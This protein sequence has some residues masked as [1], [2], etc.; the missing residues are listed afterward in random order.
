[1]VLSEVEALLKQSNCNIIFPTSTKI[2]NSQLNNLIWVMG[3]NISS[4]IKLWQHN[5]ILQ[6]K[7]F[8]LICTILQHE[9]VLLNI[10]LQNEIVLSITDVKWLV[11][12][13]TP[14]LRCA[15]NVIWKIMGSQLCNHTFCIFHMSS[16]N[17]CMSIDITYCYVIIFSW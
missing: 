5:R 6:H 1:M 3:E 13:H 7:L 14:N 12:I 8:L 10:T 16:N 11:C 4:V 9:W 15:N 2:I 17:K